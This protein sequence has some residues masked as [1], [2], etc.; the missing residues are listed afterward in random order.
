THGSPSNITCVGSAPTSSLRATACQAWR[1]IG[2]VLSI[3][4][5]STKSGKVPVTAGF[6][7]VNTPE[8]IARVRPVTYLLIHGGGSSA[9][10]WDRLRPR[11]DQP[12]LAIDLP[13]RNGKPADL[14][15]L[16]VD[17]E[18]AS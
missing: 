11:L 15:T 1:S 8:P 5:M 14:A 2:L 17:E 12:A 7:R 9:R 13:G 3:T 4:L 18:V 6:T 16:T 10:F